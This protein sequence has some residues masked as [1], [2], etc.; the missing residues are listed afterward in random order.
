MEYLKNNLALIFIFLIS[1]LPLY[2]LLTP[3]LPITHDGLDHAA[4]IAS[5]YK[6]L[7]EGILIPRWAGNL[8]WGYGHPVLMFLYPLPSYATSLFHL[9][10]FSF[11]DSLK[12]TF[13]LTYS[14]SGI[15]MFAWLKKFLNTYA[16]LIGSTFYLFAPY[17]FVDLYVRGALGEHVAFVFL[18]LILIFI[19]NIY[20]QKE[21]KKIKYYYI[22]SLLA[23]LS[24]AFLI[25][26]HNAISLLFIP[27][28]LFYIFYL[29]YEK[30]SIPRLIL[31]LISLFTGLLLSFFFWFPA[32]IEGK[33]TL[34]DIVT[35]GEY[36]DRFIAIKSLIYSSWSF[37]G[38][39]QFSVNI[40][41]I[42]VIILFFSLILFFKLF[43]DKD[44][45]KYL[46]IGAFIFILTSIF[47]MLKESNLIWN[48]LTI[49]QKLQ[50]PWRFLSIIVFCS[51]LIG[52]IFIYKLNFGNKKIITATLLILTIIST[53][54]YW[55]AKEYKIINDSFFE[56]KYNSTTDTGESSPIWSIR[57]MDNYP[58]NQIELIEGNADIV[59][60]NNLS[61]IH[62]YVIKND[63]K[64]RI[65]EN[66]LYF[67]GWK[68]YDNFQLLDNIEFQDPK[69]RGVMTFYLDPGMHNIIIK[70]ENTKLRQI[71][72]YVSLVTIIVI[73]FIPGL[74]LVNPNLKIDKYKW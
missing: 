52:A 50:F 42:Q 73:L 3:G 59:K 25:L 55:H 43:K 33:Y 45:I 38:T 57:S 22:N 7:T 67:P 23:S 27:F 15:F 5:F 16:A 41:L 19:F 56:N 46:F 72:E 71:S 47:L 20:Y 44:K 61:N 32:F 60:L 74:F 64:V 36:S 37:G 54:S 26:S 58:K 1:L 53:F 11:V 17:R 35:K 66:T 49:L 29:Y 39:G 9:F 40:G 6:S 65:R 12:I 48:N 28:V 34:R 24:F 21:I 2:N 10:G 68:I 13:A 69:N 18:P 63:E 31:S 8:N 62:E 4:R 30:K 70:F 14:L 51:S